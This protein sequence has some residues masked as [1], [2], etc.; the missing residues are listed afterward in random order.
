MIGSGKNPSAPCPLI[1]PV[2]TA[3]PF[4]MPAGNVGDWTGGT[5]TVVGAGA[6]VVGPDTGCRAEVPETP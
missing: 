6:A 4:Q 2:A 3:V 5:D 1:P